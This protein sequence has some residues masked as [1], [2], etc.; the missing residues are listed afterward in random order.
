[1]GFQDQEGFQ[2]CLA[3]LEYLALKAKVGPRE[4]RGPWV[5]LDQPECL[6]TKGQLDL[7]V[8]WGPLDHLVRLV[9]VVSL[10]SQDFLGL[11]VLLVIQETL[12]N[13]EAKV[14]K[15]QQDIRDPWVSQ[16]LGV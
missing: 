7:R 12:A 9:P 1:V 5:H 16:D 8:Q 6:A 14:P 10:V 3:L 11:M 15:G 2:V 13:L 4:T